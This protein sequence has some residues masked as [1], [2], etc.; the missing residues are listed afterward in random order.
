MYNNPD[1][2]YPEGHESMS[3]DELYRALRVSTPIPKEMCSNAKKYKAIRP[4]T[5]GCQFCNDKWMRK[6]Y[7]T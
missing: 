3:E 4:P 5:C 6:N 2:D 1:L 7:E